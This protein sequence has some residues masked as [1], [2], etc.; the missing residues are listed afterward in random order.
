MGICSAPCAEARA[1]GGVSAEPSPFTGGSAGTSACGASGAGEACGATIPSAGPDGCC[2]IESRERRFAIAMAR[3]REMTSLCTSVKPLPDPCAE[4]RH[5]PSCS[6]DGV[7]GEPSAEARASGSTPTT[8]E[9]DT[10]KMPC[11]KSSSVSAEAMPT[12]RCAEDEDE[13]EDDEDEPPC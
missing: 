11:T 3:L 9:P 7:A 8:T 5:V 13:D 1:S 4:A 6:T 2:D 10:G 12:E